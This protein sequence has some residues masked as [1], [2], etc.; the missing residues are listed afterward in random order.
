[1]DTLVSGDWLQGNQIPTS[2]QTKD[3]K[4]SNA[5]FDNYKE[6]L[7]YMSKQV[8]YVSFQQSQVTCVHLS[9]LPPASHLKNPHQNT[10]DL[11]ILLPAMQRI[12][13]LSP[14]NKQTASSTIYLAC[15]ISRISCFFLVSLYKFAYK[16]LLCH[17]LQGVK[18]ILKKKRENKKIK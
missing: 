14:K 11:L 4:K 12:S 1:M 18:I 3:E 16:V 17:C 5:Q 8:D 15:L 2:L 6:A 7:L 10:I 13:I 9:S